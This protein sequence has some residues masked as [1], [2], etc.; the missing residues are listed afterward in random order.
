MN[1][2]EQDVL[3]DDDT[4][5]Q[6]SQDSQ[7]GLNLEGG[8]GSGET[9]TQI[10]ETPPVAPPDP[11]T[12]PHLQG[13]TPQ[14]IEALVNLLESTV[15]SQNRRMEEIRS[16][17]VNQPAAPAPV[18]EA[19][20]GDFFDNPLAHLRSE[21]KAAVDPINAEIMRLKAQALVDGAWQAVAGKYA[22]FDKYR[23]YIQQMLN[24]R[25]VAPEEVSPELI[26]SLYFAAVGWVART[27]KP[28]APAAPATPP[29]A[30]PQHR[31][32]NAPLPRN[33]PLKPRELTEQERRL[34]RE[35][36]MTEDDYRAWGAKNEDEVAIAEVS[37]G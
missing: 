4:Q 11:F 22:D 3:L 28:E 20:T 19:P 36:G 12:H 6:N 18:S 33:T 23:P 1:T 29:S 15:Q 14:E 35:F 37:N 24:A 17:P 2:S 32:S 21:L 27:Q 34:A 7:E 25:G 13:K 9:G 5:S 16:V 26:E 10:G 30:P 31:P 8:E